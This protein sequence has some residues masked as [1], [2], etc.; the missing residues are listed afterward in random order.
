MVEANR[1]YKSQA[2]QRSHDKITTQFASSANMAAE[3]AHLDAL[4][5]NLAKM[6]GRHERAVVDQT[7]DVL[8]EVAASKM[9]DNAD[10]EILANLRKH[11]GQV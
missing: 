6:P 5:R 3:E 11:I 8:F 4:S 10:K 7:M 2:L 9:S 1:P